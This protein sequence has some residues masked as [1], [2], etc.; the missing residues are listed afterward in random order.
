MQYHEQMNESSESA[1]E[2]KKYLISNSLKNWST[3]IRQA[4]TIREAIYNNMNIHHVN[5]LGCSQTRHNSPYSRIRHIER[6]TKQPVQMVD[7]ACNCWCFLLATSWIPG[8]ARDPLS[9]SL[10]PSLSPLSPIR[11]CLLPS[12]PR[13][14][15]LRSG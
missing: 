13:I 2:L 12:L 8:F 4:I 14:T 10:S 7:R 9:R 1:M 15:R 6:I 3:K 5:K 11:P